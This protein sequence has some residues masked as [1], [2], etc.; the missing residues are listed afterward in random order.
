MLPHHTAAA[1]L[2][3][4]TTTNG[5]TP[6]AAQTSILGSFPFNMWNLVRVN[7]PADSSNGNVPYIGLIG[8]AGRPPV[9][10]PLQRPLYQPLQQPLHSGSQTAAASVSAAGSSQRSSTLLQRDRRS[11]CSAAV[12]GSSHSSR[13]TARRRTLP[14]NQ[15][16]EEV[17]QSALLDFRTCL[18][19][20]SSE[21]GNSGSSNSGGGSGSNS[22]SDDDSSPL[23]MYSRRDLRGLRLRSGTS[24][25]RRFD[26]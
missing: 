18:H 9:S 25:R 10:P 2:L 24:I 17:E 3:M 22:A 5:R 12:T 23:P 19:N 13:S 11:S 14:A 16:D 4:E 20:S 15:L 21:E 6:V 1:P 26:T 7:E 8:G